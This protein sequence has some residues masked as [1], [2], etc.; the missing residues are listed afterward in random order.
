MTTTDTIKGKMLKSFYHFFYVEL[1]LYK[2][3]YIVRTSRFELNLW[4]QGTRGTR[5]NK[6]PIM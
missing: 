5:P 4:V 2:Y 3:P 6:A 1:Q